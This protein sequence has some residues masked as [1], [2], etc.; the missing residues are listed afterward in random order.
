MSSSSSLSM[1]SAPVSS[2]NAADAAGA[3]G[4]GDNETSQPTII[5]GGANAIANRYC[6]SGGLRMEENA[7]AGI[8]TN[9]NSN[10]ATKKDK[11][12]LPLSVE[13]ALDKL[14]L[15]VNLCRDDPSYR[16]FLNADFR[17]DFQN[18]ADFLSFTRE[19]MNCHHYGEAGQDF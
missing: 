3:G 2:P 1:P 14:A 12:S 10:K 13:K 15:I 9:A 17:H 7:T 8:K 6:E 16:T 18:E 4:S 11:Q 5:F 19:I